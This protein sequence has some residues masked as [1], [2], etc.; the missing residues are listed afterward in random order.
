MKCLF[1]Q[2]FPSGILSLKLGSWVQIVLAAMFLRLWMRK[3]EEKVFKSY[4][5]MGEGKGEEE[6]GTRE[7][8]EK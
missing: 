5:H 7:R 3:A 2:N 4:I 8:E 6:G 1:I